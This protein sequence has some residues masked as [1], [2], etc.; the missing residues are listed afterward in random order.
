EV[1]RGVNH[2]LPTFLSVK[3]RRER[4]YMA[5]T[6]RLITINRTVYSTEEFSALKQAADRAGA[7]I[8]R[9]TSLRDDAGIN[10]ELEMDGSRQQ[11]YRRVFSLLESVRYL[12]CVENP[13]RHVATQ[14]DDV[15]R[16][17]LK[18][19]PNRVAGNR[20][21]NCKYGRLFKLPI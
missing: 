11:F 13:K 14:S 1:G 16:T 18:D 21:P 9:T 17:H 2:V 8:I 5:E 6:K 4:Y 20:P 10:V 3:Y 19:V 15:A 7:R 12:F